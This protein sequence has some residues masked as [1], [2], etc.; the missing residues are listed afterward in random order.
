MSEESTLK[1]I[2][3]NSLGYPIYYYEI[4]QKEDE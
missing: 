2:F 3:F 1:L 4:K